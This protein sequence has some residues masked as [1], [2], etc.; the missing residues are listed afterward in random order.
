MFKI[1]NQMLHSLN[2]E[3]KFINRYR[4]KEEE[5][6]NKLKLTHLPPSTKKKQQH[7]QSQA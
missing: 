2:H 3:I 5:E 1:V 4:E 7:T 6:K